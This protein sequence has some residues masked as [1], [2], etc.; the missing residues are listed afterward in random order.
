MPVTERTTIDALL[1]ESLKQYSQMRE[2]LRE[3]KSQLDGHSVGHISLLLDRFNQLSGDA[4]KIDLEIAKHLGISGE[5]ERLKEKIEEK[6]QLQAD[7]LSLIE[8]TVPKAAS[9]KAIL[10]GEIHTVSRGRRAISGYKSGSSSQGRIV[11][12]SS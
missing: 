7:I 12:R 4:R 6:V 9:V 1:E 11:N 3:M 2:V 5:A 8:Q 10:A